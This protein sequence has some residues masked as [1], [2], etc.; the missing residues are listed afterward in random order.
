MASAGD[1]ARL[2]V[3]L[4]QAVAAQ[5][6]NPYQVAK[7]TGVSLTGVQNLLNGRAHSSLRNL[8]SIFTAL[9]YEIQIAR[10]GKSMVKPGTGRG[11]GP[12]PGKRRGKG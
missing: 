2:L 8:E 12:T 5:D 1:M 3:L 7:A 10:R 6:T 11:H 9:G 4:R